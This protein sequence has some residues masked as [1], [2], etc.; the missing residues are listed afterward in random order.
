MS[1]LIRVNLAALKRL[2]YSCIVEVPDD[3]DRM[4]EL[5]TEV[6]ERTDGSEFTEDEMY[7]E[8]GDCYVEPAGKNPNPLFTIEDSK[9]VCDEHGYLTEL[10]EDAD[11]GDTQQQ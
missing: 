11:G 7:W 2:E 3:Y 9:F 1:K 5:A 8:R 10:S 6:Y 4:D